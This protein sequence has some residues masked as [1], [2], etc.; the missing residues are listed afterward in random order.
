MIIAGEANDG[1][2]VERPE[3]SLVVTE[4]KDIG[5]AIREVEP[6]LPGLTV[7]FVYIDA[8]SLAGDS[9]HEIAIEET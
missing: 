5:D 7:L 1:I 6:A 3:S 2:G 8:V 9:G 4:T